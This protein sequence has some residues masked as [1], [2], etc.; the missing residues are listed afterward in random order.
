M[1]EDRADLDNAIALNSSMANAGRLVGPSLAGLIVAGFGEGWCFLID[2]ISYFAVIASLF[3]MHVAIAPPGRATQSMVEQMREGWD[4]VRAFVP[5]RTILSLFAL[6]S[7]MGYPYM[8]LLPIFAG[9]VLH[10]GPHTLGWL[11]GAAGVGALTSALS[12]ATRRSV[13]GLTRMIQIAATMLGVALILFGFSRTLWVSLV[14]ML[15]MGFGLLQ[16]ASAANT[17]I[18]SLVSDDKRARVMSYYTMAYFG[19]APVGSLLAGALAHQI[20][21]PATIIATGVCCLFGATW[22]TYRRPRVEAAV[23]R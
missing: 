6:V 11:T 19:A 18:Q 23:S 16:S 7:L 10:G 8:V 4:Y 13:V 15:F 1:V 5:I 22:F 17:V 21:A 9:D 12:L 14:L 3:M 20:G 2:G